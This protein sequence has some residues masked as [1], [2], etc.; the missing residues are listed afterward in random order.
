MGNQYT[1]QVDPNDTIPQLKAKIQDVTGIPVANQ[2]RL[3]YEHVEL[4]SCVSLSSGATLCLVRKGDAA[5]PGMQIE[6]RHYHD[7]GE[8]KTIKKKIL[9]T[10]NET[11]QSLKRKIQNS[12]LFGIPLSTQDL[13]FGTKKLRDDDGRTLTEHG[14]SKETIL[15]LFKKTPGLDRQ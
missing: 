2:A 12:N 8:G 10:P 7:D 11:V 3:L 15:T 14:I 4:A 6:V 13:Y 1:L 5:S 9:V